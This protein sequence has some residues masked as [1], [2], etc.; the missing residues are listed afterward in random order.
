MKILTL[1]ASSALGF[2]GGVIAGPKTRH[3]PISNEAPRGVAPFIVARTVARRSRALDLY[4]H[5][6]IYIACI[7]RRVVSGR[8]VRRVRVTGRGFACA[9][10]A[11]LWIRSID[12]ASRGS[13][14]RGVVRGISRDSARRGS[15]ARCS[16]GARARAAR[17]GAVLRGVWAGVRARGGGI[18]RRGGCDGVWICI[19]CERVTR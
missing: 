12:D 16:R 6:Y 3:P 13:R 7:H 5:I 9:S 19:R 17:G 14:V 4:I 8:R 1:V 10:W 15:H 11:P 2:T 18:D